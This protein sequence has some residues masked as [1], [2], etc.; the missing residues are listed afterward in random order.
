MVKLKTKDKNID[1]SAPISGQN[2]GASQ[3]YT[4]TY[5]DA[6]Q[7]APRTQTNQ[8]NKAQNENQPAVSTT[9]DNWDYKTA[10][11]DFQGKPLEK[12]RFAGIE[13]KPQGFDP[14]GQPFFGGG[15]KG[16]LQKWGYK[17]SEEA[18][19]DSEADSAWDAYWETSK[20][21]S[22]N[23]I[24]GFT[25]KPKTQEEKNAVAKEQ[26]GLFIDGVKKLFDAGTKKAES[27][28][29]SSFLTPLLRG[30]N[31]GVGMLLDTFQAISE[32]PEKA[33][34][35]TQA[36]RDYTETYGSALPKID[37]DVDANSR[38]AAYQ[39]TVDILTNAFPPI[40]AWNTY[41]RFFAA[42]GT[43]KEKT[44][45]IKSGWVEGQMLYSELIEPTIRAEYAARV[46]AGEDP[47]LLTMELENPWAEL[48]GEM[49]LDPLNVIGAFGKAQKAGSTIAEA[50]KVTEKTGALA[51]P[52]LFE[53]LKDLGNIST[54]A[55]ASAKIEGL[56]DDI[57]R[58]ASEEGR[59]IDSAQGW[60]LTELTPAGN[61]FRNHRVVGNFMSN[62]TQ[63]IRNT[64][65]SVDDVMEYVTA[66]VKRA[67]G[68]RDAVKASIATLSHSPLGNLSYNQAA[69]ETGH[70]LNSLM[71]DGDSLVK[72]I[73]SANG[74]WNEMRKILDEKIVKALD[75]TFPSVDDMAK[76]ADKAKELADAG[77]AVDTK[78]AKLAEKYAELAKTNPGVVKWSGTQKFLERNLKG[79]NGFLANNY[80]SLSYGYATRN[81]I[82][83]FVTLFADNGFSWKEGIFPKTE[84]LDNFIV[85]QFGELP[86]SLRGKTLTKSVTEGSFMSQA[87]D[88]LN[89]WKYSPAALADWGETYASKLIFTKYYKQT[90]D[91]ALQLGAALPDVATW[92]KAG[93]TTEQANDFVNLIKANDYSEVKAVKAFTEKYGAGTVD[94]WKML[95]WVDPNVK[96][97]LEEY[98]DYWSQIVKLTNT[99]GASQ[100]EIFDKIDDLKR[101]IRERA[102]KVA[103]EP[104]RMDQSDPLWRDVADSQSQ[105]GKFADAGDDNKVMALKVQFDRAAAELNESFKSV[106]SKLKQDPNNGNLVDEIMEFTSD[107]NR[108]KINER[109]I[110]ET[111]ERRAWAWEATKKSRKNHVGLWDEAILGPAPKNYTRDQLTEAVW[112]N[113]RESRQSVWGSYFKAYVDKAQDLA[114]KTGLEEM[115]AKANK[116]LIELEQYRNYI[117]NDKGI[118]TQV[119]KF[120]ASVAGDTTNGNNV[121]KLAGTY[122]L[123]SATAD[124]K[125]LDKKILA[126]INKAGG[127]EYAKLDDVPLDVA[128][129]AIAKY[130]GHEVKGFFTK[131]S[132]VS[133]NDLQRVKDKAKAIKE[134]NATG[135]SAV[136]A[137]Q[138]EVQAYIDSITEGMTQKQKDFGKASREARKTG[139]TVKLTYDKVSEAVMNLPNEA[140]GFTLENV[141]KKAEQLGV[142]V[143]PE[144]TKFFDDAGGTA[145]RRDIIEFAARLEMGKVD[146]A[147]SGFGDTIPK[148]IDAT[149][150]VPRSELPPVVSER[151]KVMAQQLQQEMAGG[152]AGGFSK[153]MQGAGE[154]GT[155][156]S[157]TNAPW[158]KEINKKYNVGRDAVD[159]AIKRI[160]ADK[161]SDKGK[162]VEIVKEQI[163]DI[164][165]H[166]GNGQPPDLYALQELGAPEKVM[167]DALDTF[168][169]MNKSNMSMDEALQAMGKPAGEA[170]ALTPDTS[171]AYYDDA[172]N[173]V[174]PPSFSPAPVTEGLPVPPPRD[175]SV[176]PVGHVHSETSQGML[177]ALEHIKEGIKD[178]WGFKT[179]VGA[180]MKAVKDLT[181]NLTENMTV[182][183]SKAQIVAEKY[184]DFALLPYGETKNLDFAMSLV[185]PYQFWYSRSYSNWMKRA[186]MTN[187]EII[188]RYA[189]LKEAMASEQKGLPDWWKSQLNVSKLFGVETENPIYIN[190]EAAVW[191]LYG[192]TG[193]DFNDPSKR[194]NWFT[195]AL[196][197]MGKFGPS[198]WA[199][200]Q[201]GVAAAYAMQGEK[202]MASKWGTRAIP[203]T[204]T[205]KAASSYFGNPIELDPNVQLFSGNGLFD[206]KAA[207]PYEEG[208]I[209]R[210][211][212][213]MESEGI[214]QDQLLEAARTHSGPLWEEAYKRSIQQRA[215]G[216]LASFF[217]GIGFKG[218]T[219]SDIETDNFY[220]E[221]GRARNLHEAGYMTD[222]QYSQSFNDLRE[223]Y[224]FMDII[225]LSRRAGMGRDAAYAYNVISRIPPGSTKDIYNLIGIDPE[226]A[227]KFYD[228]GGKLDGM[229]ETEKA[230]FMAAMVDA[231]AILAIPSNSTRREWTDAKNQYSNIKEQM[232]QE[233]GADI[234]DKISLYFGIDDKNQARAF[235]QAH[236]EVSAA[237]D[238]QTAMIANNPR[239][240][241]YY[242]GIDTIE[243]YNTGLMY[244]KLEQQFGEDITSIESAYFEIYDS[245]EKKTYLR[246]NPQLKAYWDEKDKIK[247][248][249]ARE[250]LKFGD[251]LPEPELAATGNEPQNPTQ[252]NLQNYIATD[253][254]QV[255]QE[256]WQGLSDPMK[257]LLQ[258]YY[259]G[260]ELPYAV[261]KNLDY[262]SEQY[263]MSRQEILNLLSTQSGN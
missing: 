105:A 192:L 54:D 258:G 253:N 199:P 94:K 155:R 33:I 161:G 261:S 200:I 191:P 143:P 76:A 74:D 162:T 242:G 110:K 114:G 77:K 233:Y 213:A 147:V 152:E 59:R 135:T 231:G 123:A 169:E 52:V 78:T 108:Q 104:V 247:A 139:T 8:T 208:R 187:P 80:F 26:G 70:V 75:F 218:R 138:K 51:D 205:I 25:N 133:A 145:S 73:K 180:D 197:D 148:I 83:N 44:A 66:L 32:V 225:L 257:S 12:R 130:Q 23:F 134:A 203:L 245:A 194:T 259:N 119:P 35:A 181:K 49:I 116:S 67:S 45:A 28:E 18:A 81:L 15:V 39:D 150:T 38:I 189:N 163:M 6:Q 164:L 62:A 174:E 209:S 31:A 86:V 1:M 206:M 184:R 46:K 79:I 256:I 154:T 168:N 53:K 89:A 144:F 55:Q 57:V 111:T 97:G 178:R 182:A 129:Q 221:Y 95:D 186:F 90:L 227:Q 250:L 241:K 120:A 226:T 211:L 34:G 13:I 251:R 103:S 37:T 190:L 91:N 236:P 173:L 195:S 60:K 137:D 42:P 112:N 121:R 21:F 254:T 220:A 239:L 10:Q 88:K 65:G 101:Q 132:P 127:S 228:S 126:I 30:T 82:Q 140:A 198:L 40:G 217:F 160:I 219:A 193:T 237:M 157:S 263:G 47:Y 115:F 232:A 64:G 36:M 72:A 165:T 56:T 107:T 146:N 41:A 207:D 183:R 131:D 170:N 68:D 27:S 185:Y 172:G 128:E 177:D 244:D 50:T 167:Q 149:T 212:A 96:K 156:Y 4:Q 84:R 224:P 176:P 9:I 215:P 238:M 249:N 14:N 202:E 109:A 124:G 117:Y 71:G 102:N 175:P 248:E 43:L 210:A 255:A 118:Y 214:P 63:A 93:F 151:I 48:A 106:I 92:N 16:W 87:F 222:E 223:K 153:A 141:I 98:E 29:A 113:F 188:S 201:W 24:K 19:T 142:T 246:Q 5:Q 100:T 17:L 7:N 262:L 235:L 22:D 243:R 125:S 136:A 166:G 85:S 158:Y 252:E 216:Q 234:Q 179:P 260:E 99:D 58:I 196:D 171:M 3:R 240:V 2:L 230:R 20:K 69:F 204:A 122:G 159:A 229:S 61:R 11:T